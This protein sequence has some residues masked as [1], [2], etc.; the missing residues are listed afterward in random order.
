MCN[1][2]SNNVK[3]VTKRDTDIQEIISAIKWDWLFQ[4]FIPRPDEVRKDWILESIFGWCNWEDIK[5]KLWIPKWKPWLDRK[6]LWFKECPYKQ[7]WYDWQT[8]NWGSKWDIERWE[9]REPDCQDV[10][11]IEFSYESAWSPHLKWWEKLSDILQC[12]IEITFDEP[13]CDFSWEYIYENWECIQSIDYDDWYYG[14][15]KECC[16]C[17]WKYDNSNPDDWWDKHHTVC[18]YC[19]EDF[20]S[21][22]K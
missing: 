10:H 21:K 17:K 4:H 14:N 22:K 15:W 19:W 5:E 6:E 7:L 8:E 16:I 20:N 2:C 11:L 1:R 13:W 3:I 9:D 18:I 12:R